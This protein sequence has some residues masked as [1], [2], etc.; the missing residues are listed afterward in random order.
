VA[1]KSAALLFVSWPSGSLTMLEP[2]AAVVG[3][4]VA[5][6]PSTSAFVA[7]PQP[8]PSTAAPEASRT[9]TPPP[10]AA[11]PAEN[12]WSADFAPA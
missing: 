12:D 6:V 7:V 8:T 11:R 9:A 1:E 10:D 5:G 2:G 4:A 3:G